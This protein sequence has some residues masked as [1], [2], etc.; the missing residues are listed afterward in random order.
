MDMIIRGYAASGLSTPLWIVGTGPQQ[1]E[2]QALAAQTPGV[3][4]KG[5]L[6]QH[7]LTQAYQRARFVV[8]APQQEDYGLITVEAF[9]AGAP[10]LTCLD[11]GGPTELVM[12]GQSGYL[13]DPSAEG[14]AKGFQHLAGLD[15]KAREAMGKQGQHWVQDNLNWTS[16]AVNL[17]GGQVHSGGGRSQQPRAAVH[18]APDLATDQKPR[19]LA[20][21]TFPIEPVNSGGRQR[22]LGLYK[23]LSS[24]FDV[25]LMSLSTTDT[26]PTL[27]HH[28]PFFIEVRLPVSQA[29]QD[30]ARYYETRLGVSCF[31]LTV[32]QH[33]ELLSE[34]LAL[35][36][37]AADASNAIV[38]SHPYCF[39]LFES[40][41]YQSH[42]HEAVWGKPILYEAH[43]VESQLKP[44]MLPS[45][46]LGRQFAH[47]VRSLEARLLQQATFVVAC[48][49]AD[50]AYFQECLARAARPGWQAPE[51]LLAPNGLD[52]SKAQF[53][54]WKVRLADAN[55]RGFKLA[56]FIG[57]GHRPNVHAANLIL[58][59]VSKASSD[60]W[61]V[62]LGSCCHGLSLD[63]LDKT[64]SERVRLVGL[65]SDV[66]KLQWLDV[67]TVGL[68]PVGL[69]SGSNLKVAE[70]V[71]SGLG[72]I[73]TDFGARGW[74][75]QPNHQYLPIEPNPLSL[76]GA[77]NQFQA[78]AS[79]HPQPIDWQLRQQAQE[80]EWQSIGTRL[81]ASLRN[82]IG[83]T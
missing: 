66:E 25:Q 34:H 64:A 21:N 48:A 79:Q 11:A 63:G 60:W 80:F 52:T 32:A 5:F 16:L 83:P 33:P 41:G 77:L 38:F 23:G 30:R 29:L 59:T 12:H 36:R 69:G 2:L 4:M 15:A 81:G 28:A 42:S 70:Y 53:K 49:T 18:L 10:V 75:W 9:K 55:H 56:L 24:R 67:A 40:L 1:E 6:S 27:R 68:N 76:S 43:N 82:R 73:S 46:A 71:A 7:E 61:F 37:S 47:L 8:F 45:T 54:S 58:D 57:S 72:L 22:M 39:P 78:W 20:L 19:L 62:I 26:L 17:L 31:D 44:A 65:V 74:N 14:L 51:L 13:A 3:E 35:L 50:Q